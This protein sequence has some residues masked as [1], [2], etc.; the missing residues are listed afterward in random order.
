MA[1][2]HFTADAQSNRGF[3]NGG[4]P[5]TREHIEAR[6]AT[7]EYIYTDHAITLC[8]IT[9]DN[10]F[11]ES[12]ES[13]CIDPADFSEARGREIAYTEAF[14]NLWGYFGFMAMEDA[15]RDRAKMLRQAA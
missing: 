14:E 7:V 9:L 3:A 5:V 1:N 12:G 15:H 13:R 6:I 4:T 10:G 2:I 11:I 8:F